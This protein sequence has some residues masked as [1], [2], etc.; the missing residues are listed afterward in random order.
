MTDKLMSR[1]KFLAGAGAVVGAATVSGLA[2]CRPFL[3]RILGYF[4]A[5]SFIHPGI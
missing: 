1:R 3:S 2:T 4:C 5:S